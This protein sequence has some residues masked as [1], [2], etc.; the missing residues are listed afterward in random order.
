MGKFEKYMET[1]EKLRKKRATDAEWNNLLEKAADDDTIDNSEY[2][3]IWETV[4]EV[5]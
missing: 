2:W 1:I 5:Y 4:M 3:I